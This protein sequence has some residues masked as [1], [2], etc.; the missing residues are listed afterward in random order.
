MNKLFARLLIILSCVAAAGGEAQLPTD[1]AGISKVHY[2]PASG[3]LGD[4]QPFFWDGQYHV[5][6]IH[7]TIWEHIVSDDLVHWIELPTAIEGPPTI[8]S[9]SVVEHEGIFHAFYTDAGPVD[10]HE[11]SQL[12]AHAISNDLI[13]W[14]KLPEYTFGGDGVHYWNKALNPPLKR[15]DDDQSFR[16]PFVFWNEDERVWMMIFVARDIDTHYHVHGLATSTDLY[17]WQQQDYI[18]KISHRHVDCPDLFKI[19]DKW[20]LLYDHSMYQYADNLRGPFLPEE[21]LRFETSW[22]L[23]AR[24]MFD[25]K[26]QVLAAGSILDMPGK[27]DNAGTQWGGTL[28]VSRELYA[29]ADGKL[30]QKPVPEIVS[31]FTET[32]FALEGNP[33]LVVGKNG[34]PFYEPD[35]DAF[36]HY[37]TERHVLQEAVPSD[38]MLTCHFRLEPGPWRSRPNGRSSFSIGVRQQKAAPGSGYELVYYPSTSEIEVKSP[39]IAHVRK[40]DLNPE[41]RLKVRAFVTGSIIEWFVNDAYAFT[42]RAYDYRDG[43]ISFTAARCVVNVTDVSV[44]V[45]EGLQQENE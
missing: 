18:N 28:G 15:M 43:A 31:A 1:D 7:G 6:Y 10:R 41:K 39:Y 37:A 27:T 26:R 25:G 24:R 12:I 45:V 34:N 16:D 13:T 20:Y 8:W 38:Y 35:K 14:K 19:G 29:A 11:G 22:L 42:M 21:P 30:L 5:F 3:S 33:I 23:V 9:G 2:R 44:R 40:C 4:V 17:K 32:V 36:Y